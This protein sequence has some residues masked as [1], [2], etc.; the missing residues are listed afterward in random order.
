[1]VAQFLTAG[2][3]RRLL[4]LGAASAANLAAVENA[5]GSLKHLKTVA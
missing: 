3:A 2:R 1:M 5:R 4:G